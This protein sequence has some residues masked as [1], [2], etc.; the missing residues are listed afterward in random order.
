MRFHFLSRL[1]HHFGQCIDGSFV[2]FSSPAITQREVFKSL[3][4]GGE[5]QLSSS[6]SL[7]HNNVYGKNRVSAGPVRPVTKG[8]KERAHARRLSFWTGGVFGSKRGKIFIWSGFFIA[9]LIVA[10]PPF[11]RGR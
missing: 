5:L 3:V 1:P 9:E 4:K 8:R 10:V 6:Q 7:L 2:R 11:D